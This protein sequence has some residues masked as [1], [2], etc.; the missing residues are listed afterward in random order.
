[1]LTFTIEQVEE[2]AK[3]S[4]KRRRGYG[5][6]G[7]TFSVA[8]LG[9]LWRT[10]SREVQPRW[11]VF[12]AEDGAV[13][14]V[15]A[16][17]SQG[18]HLGGYALT[19]HKEFGLK[20][21]EA[22]VTVKVQRV[23]DGCSVVTIADEAAF[24]LDP[25]PVDPGAPVSFV[26]MTDAPWRARCGLTPEACLRA[27]EEAIQAGGLEDAV[28]RMPREHAAAFR[29]GRAAFLAQHVPAACHAVAM[30]DHR[31]AAPILPGPGFA[32]YL[33]MRAIGAGIAAHA[34]FAPSSSYEFFADDALGVDP[35]VI[36][37]GDYEEVVALIGAAS[38]DFIA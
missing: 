18:A 28:A 19:G 23:H 14:P 32:L 2:G 1:M 9:A 3:K 29:R 34:D 22:S 16:N 21:G 36:F 26:S 12:A 10:G 30:L 15:L 20:R 38:K 4:S 31:V 33:L 7:K 13:R 25:G 37:S 5:P 6:K 35:P 27:A 17:L 8:G 24:A 11:F